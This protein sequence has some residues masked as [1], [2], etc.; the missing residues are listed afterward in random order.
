MEFGEYRKWKG[1]PDLNFP[2]DII[3]VVVQSTLDT[4]RQC[5]SM[6]S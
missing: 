1:A 3:V 6:L 5:G 4:R 2:Y